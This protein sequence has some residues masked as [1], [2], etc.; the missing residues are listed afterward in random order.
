MGVLSTLSRFFELYLTENTGC[1]G[2]GN[3]WYQNPRTE[4]FEAFGPLS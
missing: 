1:C 3:Y 4:I 2:T